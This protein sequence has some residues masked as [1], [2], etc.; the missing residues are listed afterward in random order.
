MAVA[1][2]RLTDRIEAAEK[3]SAQAISGIDESVRGALQRLVAAEREQVAVAARF[4]GA[5]DEI[6]TDQTRAGERLRRIEA[7]AAGPRSAEALRALEGAWARSPATSTRAR[8]AP[9]RPSPTWNSAWT[10]RPASGPG[11]PRPWSRKSS[12]AWASAW[13]PPRPARP[14][15]CRP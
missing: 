4:E 14:K 3:R 15:P 6:K 9:A 11:T 8:P 10:T 13:K 7:E 12:A 1:L 5:V 2:D